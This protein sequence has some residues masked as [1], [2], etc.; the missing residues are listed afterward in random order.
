MRKNHLLTYPACAI[1]ERTEP[2]VVHH[3]RYRG[4]RGESE[5]PGDL[6]TLCEHHHDDLHRQLRKKGNHALIQGTLDYIAT[7]RLIESLV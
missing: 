1:C 6:V 7:K 2:V 3:L 5:L 4:K